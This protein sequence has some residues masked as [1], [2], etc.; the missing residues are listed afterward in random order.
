MEECIYKR[1]IVKASTSKRI[2]TKAKK[3]NWFTQQELKDLY[4]FYIT[5]TPLQ[6][7][8]NIEEKSLR[9][10]VEKL[11]NAIASIHLQ[12]DLLKDTK[13]NLNRNLN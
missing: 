2:H 10:I 1:Q 3:D 6:N 7:A 8:Q 11:P 12:D 5:K 4:V 13:K 9:Q